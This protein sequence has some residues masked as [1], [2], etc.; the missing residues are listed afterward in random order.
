MSYINNKKYNYRNLSGSTAVDITADFNFDPMFDHI[1]LCNIHDTDSCTVDL[2]SV[3]IAESINF[4]EWQENGH[5]N[6]DYTEPASSTETY[7]YMKNVVIPSGVT[8]QL[9]N[10]DFYIDPA[11]QIYIKLGAGS[12]TVDLSVKGPLP[13]REPG[14]YIS[15]YVD[16]RRGVPPYPVVAS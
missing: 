11:T 5:V 7:Y 6:N 10:K 2:Y 14:N 12:S 9:S 1:C 15:S 16:K 8:L 3:Y 13:Y 4:T